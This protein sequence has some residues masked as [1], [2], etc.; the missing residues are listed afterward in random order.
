VL[1]KCDYLYQSWRSRYQWWSSGKWVGADAVSE[2]EWVTDDS[3]VWTGGRISKASNNLR[4]EARDSFDRLELMIRFLMLVREL[5]C[6]EPGA[7]IAKYPDGEVS[8]IGNKLAVIRRVME[9]DTL[10]A[11]RAL[12]EIIGNLSAA[13]QSGEQATRLQPAR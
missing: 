8:A 5:F 4:G 3:F 2:F 7:G 12:R 6:T 13:L 1:R 9:S 10:A 11:D